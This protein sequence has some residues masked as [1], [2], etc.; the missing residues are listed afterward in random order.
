MSV[1]SQ[2]KSAFRKVF[3]GGSKSSSKPRQSYSRQST[4]RASRVSNYGG[5]GSRSYRDYSSGS[6]RADYQDRQA[7]EQRRRQE[8]EQKRQATTNALASISKRTDSLSSGRSS[9][10]ASSATNV[11]NGYKVAIK[12]IEQKAKNAPP[13]PK[14]AAKEASKDRAT[15][16]LAKIESERKSYNKATG[17]RYNVDKNGLKARQAQKS[18]AYDA[19]AEK[20]EVKHHP[21]AMSAARGGLSGVTFGGSEILAR[22]SKKRKET[23]AEQYYQAHKSRGAEI[24][25]EIAGSLVGFGL[26]EKGA[27]KLASKLAPK[28]LKE[29][30]E[31][32]AKKLATNPAFRKA[33]IKEAEKAGMKITD[34]VIERF[35]LQRARRVVG[36]V[37]RDMA[38]N[39]TTG[40][41]MDVNYALRDTYDENE[42]NFDIGDFGKN[43]AKNRA[44]NYGVGGLVTV[45]PALRTQKGLL[46]D[47][48]FG[49]DFL[50]KGARDDALNLAKTIAD[51]R[52]ARQAML[53][54]F[55]RDGKNAG[56][57]IDMNAL[58]EKNIKESTDALSPVK[59]SSKADD[60]AR[61]RKAMNDAFVKEGDDVGRRVDMNEIL[62]HNSPFGP[63][64]EAVDADYHFRVNMESN[65]PYATATKAR[66]TLEALSAKIQ[67]GESLTDVE[68]EHLEAYDQLIASNEL[69]FDQMAINERMLRISSEAEALSRR[70][71]IPYA[72]A[73]D[74]IL[75]A[76]HI[77]DARAAASQES[78]DVLLH[79]LEN[80]NRQRREALEAARTPNAEAPNVSTEPATTAE[81]VAKDLSDHRRMNS[82]EDIVYKRTEP[83]SG[84]EKINKAAK[85]LRT[86]IFDSL[87][88]FEDVERAQAKAAGRQ[89]DHGATDLLRRHQT[90]AN[91]SIGNQQLKWNGDRY[92]GK[93]VRNGIEIEDGKSLKDI[94]KGMDAETEREFDAYLLLKHAPDRI[95]E[96]KPIF[97]ATEVKSFDGKTWVNLNDPEACLREAELRLKKHPE[98]AKKAE[99]IYQYTQNELKNRVDAGLLKQSVVDDWNKRYPN[100]VPTA[101]DGFNEIHSISG[102][103]VGAEDLKAAK[104]SDLDI[105]SIRDQL[106]NSTTR[107]WRDMTTNHLFR[108]TFGDK[109]A[110]ELAKQP[111]GG[112][113]MVLDNT[114]NLAKSHETGK[115]YADI[116]INGQK[117]KVEIEE[118]FYEGL[119]DLYKN[120]RIGNALIDTTND[121]FS[122]VATVW[123]SLITE[124]SPIFMVKNFMRDFPEAVINTK[125]TKEF[126]T[127][128]P[129][130]MRD[131]VS[132]G[133]YSTALRDAGIS[134]STFIDLDKA[135]LTGKDKK[136]V[137]ARANELTEMYPRLVEY[138]ATFKKAGVPLEEADL[139]LRAKAA[140]NAADVTV[141]FGRSGSVGKMLNRGFVPFFNPSAQGWSKFV[142]N[143]TELDSTKSGLS[144]ALKATALGA[145]PLT[146]SNLLYK[147]NPNYQMISARDKAN[148]YIIAIG[149]ADTTN[150]FVKIPRS[151][152]ASV[153]GLPVTNIANENK[154]GWAEAIKIANDQVAPIDPLE[155]TLLSPFIAAQ[156]NETW[157]GSPIV[158]GSLEDLPKSEQYDANTSA[159]GKAL[160]KAT[161]NLPRALQISPKKADYII[162]AETGVAGDFILPMLTP[163]RQH[164]NGITGKVLAPA[165]NVVKRQFTIDS[166]T[167]NDLSTRFYDRL[168]EAETNKKSAKA[169]EADANE[170]KRMSEYSTEVSGLTKA[171]TDMQNS[172]R[173]DK[174][175]AIY[176]LQKVRN[177]LIQDAL[178]GKPAPTSGQKLDAVQKYVGTTYAINNFGSSA[179]KQAMQVYGASKY[180]KLS[181]EE[182]TKRIDA[183]ENFYKGVQAIG[184][185]EDRLAKNG[186]S[187]STTL[188][189]AVAL[190][191]VGADD[192]LFGAYQGT[193]KSRTET[194]N[195]MDRARMYIANGGSTDEFVQLENA[196]KTLGKLSN[197]DKE[198]EL[199]KINDQLA[200][201]EIDYEEYYKKQGEINY[202]AN[203][204]YVGLATSLA[205]ANAPAR[206][207]QLYDIKAKNI[208]KGIN[209]AAMGFTARD[210][211]EMAKA[212]D[213]DG[214]GYPSKKE[215]VAYVENSDV[216]DKAT[217]FD[218][219]Y[220]Y[221]GSRNPFGSVT[222]YSR[223]QAAAAG[224]AKG[225]DPISNE[226]GDFDL[227]DEESGKSGYGYR[228]RRY[229]RRW[230]HYGHGHSSKKAKVPA[231]KTIK[232][233]QFVK[234]EAL[235]NTTK[236]S[237]ATKSSAKATP[238]ELKRVKAKIDLPTVRKEY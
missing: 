138:M 174:Q 25:G 52:G 229:G 201:G 175:D 81:Q 73:V 65:E 167:Q 208:Q 7:A 193:K 226:R 228:R 182:M 129:E 170:Y 111:D 32:V 180:G 49:T 142:R 22:T 184:E 150:M 168:Q 223:D 186:S 27:T 12:K 217:L 51:E 77:E 84:R 43:L 91:R 36:A 105:R 215:I 214:N 188:T 120:G 83:V 227:E 132:G 30:G 78:D 88:A 124:W 57:R 222:N 76:R 154:M 176:G 85:S 116:F 121:A 139:A 8:Q 212:V 204:S 1:L 183:D 61:M 202:N 64:G 34:D 3:G 199:D 135:L 145:A 152:F 225:V 125:Q 16:M 98:F 38:I 224:K 192:D 75:V 233:N 53:D 86:Q 148:N 172:T 112:M 45:A 47:G 115:Y 166:V 211:R 114:I 104:G 26:T 103:T 41:A 163:S 181:E 189:K 197:Y 206:G 102:S 126:I 179:D 9:S 221:K 44:I 164:G 56:S 146:I 149:D 17:N 55:V 203:I 117:H 159:I 219:L 231:P 198:K 171:I 200:K 39:W 173:A 69:N 93:I 110:N 97:D 11:G 6:Y 162:D 4:T 205:E 137:L 178:N 20:W 50:K 2:I 196:R 232:A 90:I 79:S 187:R 35:A 71:H 67:R 151:R 28:V 156:K 165:G 123:K 99:E 60:M 169:T 213:A 24:G 109:I 128:M 18:Q 10:V 133:P 118:R 220:Y 95:R 195:K 160:G 92:S 87:S 237:S 190:A 70:S 68:R 144:F 108:E 143:I 107:N 238:P 130:A 80:Y 236:S 207:Y 74:R 141:N 42:G 100:Y 29:G 23:G 194:A 134:Q 5:G 33:A 21:K 46:K 106:A 58:L 113:E 157:Y 89:V 177:Q 209:L 63:A 136:N 161:E 59:M 119:K 54:T 131:L 15:A 218:A 185:L 122:K 216:E 82:V 153:Y 40:G 37:G 62:E 158:P 210:Y 31:S 101:R 48:L 94:Y 14:L 96:G 19:E 127:S 235:G 230:R 234:G 155:S 147:D 191:S 72:D 140:A 66:D 13:D